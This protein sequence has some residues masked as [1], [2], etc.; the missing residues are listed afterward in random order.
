MPRS[1]T[2]SIQP[3]LIL[4]LAGLSATGLIVM[5][6]RANQLYGPPDPSLGTWGT[7]EYSA[8][9]LWYDGTLTQALDP[10]GV[11]R[12]FHVEQGESAALIAGRLQS[13]GLIRSADAFRTYLVYTGLDTSI[14]AG[15][16]ELSPSLSIV[17][18]ARELQDATPADVTFV[19]LAGWRTEEVAASLATSG[20]AL[21]P[22]EFIAAART[23]PAG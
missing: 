16:Y 18:L 6:L 2:P 11:E 13:A 21:T 22:D 5:P 1:Q 14:Q 8:R 17:D 7:L 4:L 15:D 12:P 19:V 20:L 3:F 23:P 9:L 10:S